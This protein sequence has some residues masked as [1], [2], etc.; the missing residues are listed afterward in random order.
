M[1]LGQRRLVLGSGGHLPCEA[2]RRRMQVKGHA[3]AGKGEQQQ[4]ERCVAPFLFA[5]EDNTCPEQ[6]QQ[7]GGD[8]GPFS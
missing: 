6:H 7:T 2:G 5:G 8:K 3:R 4:G 1:L